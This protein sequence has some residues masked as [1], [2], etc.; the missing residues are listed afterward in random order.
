[1]WEEDSLGTIGSRKKVAQVEVLC[2]RKNDSG[3]GGGG[4][5]S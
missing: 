2:G 1:M 4:G 3:G 5:A